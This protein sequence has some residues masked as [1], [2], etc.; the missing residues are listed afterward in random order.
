[1]STILVR[2]TTIKLVTVCGLAM[3]IATAGSAAAEVRGDAIPAATPGLATPGLIA[4]ALA[5]LAPADDRVFGEASAS[6]R[7][8]GKI[9]AAAAG[10][11]IVSRAGRNK[12]GAKTDEGTSAAAADAP[13]AQTETETAPSGPFTLGR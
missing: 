13:A 3:A 5:G 9:G 7:V 8:A 11:A 4:P 10:A 1:M 6:F 12:D 2:S